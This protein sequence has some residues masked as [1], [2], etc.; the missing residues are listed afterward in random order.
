MPP[1]PQNEIKPANFGANAG[2]NANA[3]A[4]PKPST[5]RRFGKFLKRYV[6]IIVVSVVVILGALFFILISSTTEFTDET[7]FTSDPSCN[8]AGINLHGGLLT[9]I[10]NHAEGD[11]YFDYD[12]VSSE[13]I[14][15]LLDLAEGDSYIKAIILEVDSGGGLPVAGE[16]VAEALKNSQK[17]VVGV[18]RQVG[19]SA[20]YWAVSGA[21]KIFASENS[22]VGGIGVTMT[23]LNNLEKNKKDGYSLV[24]LSAGKYKDSG[25]P[26]KPLTEEER[27]LFLRDIN[28]V[29]ENFTQA[30][31]INRNLP[32]ENVKS[33]ADG[34]TVLGAK[35]LELGL[36][37]QIGGL[38]E[39]EKY[40]SEIIG[41]EVVS[42]WQ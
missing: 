19:A 15:W 30:I 17:P 12:T 9:Y 13:D 1:Q 28:I 10:P 37:D 32:I 40:L 33:L 27:N 22:D 24:E 11:S 20:S 31:S 6:A 5:G 23:Y 16:E 7:V 41:E 42:C 26:D 2:A 14:T 3:N 29:Y 34:S 38:P 18:I 21:D 4:N 25:S 35:A 39:A 8:V 36:I